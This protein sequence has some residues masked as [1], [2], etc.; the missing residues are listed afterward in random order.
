M[1]SQQTKPK[2]PM[3]GFVILGVFLFIFTIGGCFRKPLQQQDGA[4]RYHV[5]VSNIHSAVP[6]YL[7]KS[8]Y[9]NQDPLP[10]GG[11]KPFFLLEQAGGR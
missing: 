7:P 4:P 9:G 8:K 6:R 10:S 2:F 5:D 1:D 11:G 3:S